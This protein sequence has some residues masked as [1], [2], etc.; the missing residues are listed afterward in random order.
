M[1]LATLALVAVCLYLWPFVQILLHETAHVVVGKL[2]C[3]SPFALTV[4]QGPLLLRRRIGGLDV[5]IHWLPYFGVVHVRLP[6]HGLW[7]RGSLFAMAGLASDAFL[8]VIALNL[9]G[10]KVGAPD[11]SQATPGAAF[12]AFIA[13]Y[14]AVIIAVNLMPMQVVVRGV[15]LPTD[16]RQILAYLTGRTSAALAAYETNVC[17]YDP[18]FR[19]AQSWIMRGDFALMEAFSTA[20]RHMSDRRYA[21]ATAKYTQMF[22]QHGLHHAEKA[23]ILDRMACIPIIHG[24]RKFLAEA[25]SWSKE[26]RALL[27]NCKTVQGTLGSILVEQGR[28]AEGLD[29]LLPLT[30]DENATIDRALA[31]C[32]AAKA[33]HALGRTAE[34]DTCMKAARDYGQF[35]QVCSRV[36]MEVSPA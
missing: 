34:A 7:W 10:F 11:V 31:S 15:P 27:P 35:P 36:E 2:L 8:L 29:L 28:Y 3:F 26:A 30:S 5:R 32:F 12:F 13:L 16:G 19:I 18:T 22:A 9:A 20:E 25:E 17:R 1:T 33:L 21:D 4:G 6:M 14:Q 24:E 23:L